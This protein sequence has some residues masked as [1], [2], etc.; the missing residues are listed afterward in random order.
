MADDNQDMDLDE[1]IAA[2]MDAHEQPEVDDADIGEPEAE[3]APA[4]VEEPEDEGTPEPEPE[5]ET[6][7]EAQEPEAEDL[8]APPSLNAK[9]REEWKNWP[10]A[11]K[12]AMLRREADS[13]KGVEMVKAD[14]ERAKGMD[15]ALAPYQPLFNA[16]GGNAQ[17]VIQQG[18][19]IMATLQLQGGDAAAQMVAGAINQ[20]GID[21]EAINRH[22]GPGQQQQPQNVGV[23]DVQQMVQQGIA[24]YQQQQG[25]T[26]ANNEVGAFL[27]DP[28]NEFINDVQ[29]DMANILDMA[30]ARGEGMSLKEAY[31][32]AVQL[33]PDIQQVLQTRQA[34][35][36]PAKRRAA[37]SVSGAKAG[38]NIPPAPDSIEDFLNIA[39]D[40]H[41]MP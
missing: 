15:Q 27:A 8:A 12:Q 28:A 18:L 40:Q 32:R 10:D 37:S 30:A 2:A 35:V 17:Q 26:Q 25:A 5:P 22:L 36:T 4:E 39:I 7:P 41:G 29:E 14:A 11:A 33:N 13:A 21:L 9:E 31:D 38:Q 34:A 3:E 20:F 1:A 23:Q 19:N 16:N 6:E 24:Q